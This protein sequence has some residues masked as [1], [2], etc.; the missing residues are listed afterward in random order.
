[1]TTVADGGLHIVTV[2][3]AAAPVPE[4]GTDGQAEVG[5]SADFGL[6]IVEATLARDVAAHFAS[7]ALSPGLT[8]HR[9]DL[10]CFLVPAWAADMA[11]PPSAHYRPG[12]A[13]HISGPRW[14]APRRCITPCSLRQ[15]TCGSRSP[16]WPAPLG[17]TRGS[18]RPRPPSLGCRTSA[19]NRSTRLQRRCDKHRVGWYLRSY[20][21]DQIT[22]QFLRR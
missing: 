6:V 19:P 3:P 20:V 12:R 14:P 10:D 22:D 7:R 15:S 8:A 13:I 18:S 5:R 21:P 11:W 2:S 1:V 17:G 4:T 9:E 16:C